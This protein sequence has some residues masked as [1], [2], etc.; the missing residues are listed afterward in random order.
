MTTPENISSLKPSEI[1]VFGSN[2]AGRHGAGAALLA[3][4][5]FGAISGQGFGLMGQSYGIATKDERIQTLPLSKIEI[6]V[7]KFLRSAEKYP[8]K[9]FL[10]TQIGCGLAGYEPKDIAPFFRHPPKNVIL[11]ESFLKVLNVAYN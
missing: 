11:P 2:L 6:Q 3:L 1:F 4:R 7:N 5:K 8:E 10:V 9:T